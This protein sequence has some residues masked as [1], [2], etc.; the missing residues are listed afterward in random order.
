M[1]KSLLVLVTASVAMAL[2][3][4]VVSATSSAYVIGSRLPSG[5]PQ[6]TLCTFDIPASE[7]PCTVS[8]NW[9]AYGLVEP[10]GLTSPL[11]GLI[12]RWSILV[13]S[14]PPGTSS[15]KVQL[16]TLTGWRGEG[17]GNLIEVPLPTPGTYS[18]FEFLE[19]LP[20][21]LGQGLGITAYVSGSGGQAGLTVLGEVPGSGDVLVWDKDLGEKNYTYFDTL[22]D[23]QLMLSATVEPDRDNDGLGDDTQDFCVPASGNSDG[24]R[25]LGRPPKTAFSYSAPQNFAASGKVVIS[26]RSSEAGTA[27]ARG[28][29]RVGGKGGRTYSLEDSERLIPAR[30]RVNVRLR[31]SAGTKAAVAKA[32]AARK[33]VVA[34]VFAY[35]D[36]HSGGRGPESEMVIPARRPSSS[37]MTAP[38]VRSLRCGGARPKCRCCPYWPQGKWPNGSEGPTD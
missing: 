25:Q 9:L 34:E 36:G 7:I 13:G 6:G 8:Q 4:L 35:A 19:N 21:A 27:L 11:T 20:I 33:K 29:I 37:K 18:Y 14:P 2:V 12:T 32:L 5:Q 26:L 24:C 22:Q 3:T 28:R 15:I 16:R 23:S 1:R 31:L 17:R 38:S 10:A 30:K